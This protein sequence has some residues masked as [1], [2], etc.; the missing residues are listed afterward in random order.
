ME[1]DPHY[2]HQAVVYQQ[3]A[4]A[5]AQVQAA[6]VFDVARTKNA[7]LFS[8]LQNKIEQNVTQWKSAPISK[9]RCQGQTIKKSTQYD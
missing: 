6:L 7:V 1:L 3:A 2:A 5:A 8:V 4:S 9:N